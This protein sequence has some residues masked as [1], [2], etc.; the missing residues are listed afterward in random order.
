MMTKKK[1][2]TR[3][4]ICKK[5]RLTHQ[6]QIKKYNDLYC[7]THKEQRREYAK[8][9][10][11]NNK[12]KIKVATKKYNKEH[13]EQRKI[14][15]QIKMKETNGLYDVWHGMKQRCFNI[16]NKNYS[17][18]GQRGIIVCEEWKNSFQAFYDWAIT[19]G[20]QKGL[21]ID[22][23]NNDGNYCPENCRFVTCTENN[24]NTRKNILTIE[25]VREIRNLLQQG[26]KQTDIVK[27]YNLD[28]A[29]VSNIKNNK[30]WK[31]VVK[32]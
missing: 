30:I 21:Q 22:R 13:K 18:Y 29:T 7:I 17:S 14:A 20:H 23:R 31:E 16:N 4:E 1:I 32:V 27:Q 24:R 19:H 2:K 6:E 10:K 12:E 26:I 15:R 5:Y 9:Y 3:Q 11:L 25:R 28:S 8:K